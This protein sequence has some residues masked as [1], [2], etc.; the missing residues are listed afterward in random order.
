[1]KTKIVY[2]AV[3]EIWHWHIALRRPQNKRKEGSSGERRLFVGGGK[4]TL[5]TEI[6]SWSFLLLLRVM[7]EN[8]RHRLLLQKILWAPW[9]YLMVLFRKTPW[10]PEGGFLLRSRRKH[11]KKRFESN[12]GFEDWEWWAL[13]PS[14]LSQGGWKTGSGSGTV[15]AS[16]PRGPGTV[17]TLRVVVCG[18]HKRQHQG[19]WPW[20]P[21]YRA[22]DQAPSWWNCDGW[23]ATL[24]AGGGN[25]TLPAV[26]HH[27]GCHQP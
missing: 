8:H 13:G 27:T 6:E 24:V 1:M 21:T 7:A 9:L 14:A 3:E 15:G 4:C 23:S 26:R 19:L 10:L 5:S 2:F 20:E 25:R 18:S 17:G 12:A 22:F 11:W 16:C